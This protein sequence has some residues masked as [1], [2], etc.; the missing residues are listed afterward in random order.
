MNFKKIFSVVIFA[1]IILNLCLSAYLI[2][3][4][5]KIDYLCV[6]GQSCDFVQNSSYA[7][8][9]EIKLIY[10]SV[11]AFLFLLVLF[12]INE[13]WFLL[14]TI[15]GT[16]LAIYFISI[17]LFILKAIC[18]TCFVVDFTMIGIFILS[19]IRYFV[20]KNKKKQIAKKNVKQKKSK[21]K[22]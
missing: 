21:K 1:L 13:K 14:A 15:V 8:L 4:S 22:K 17:Q 12:F 7:S 3:D 2:Y 5:Q 19:I 18:S 6:A 9:F 11:F 20:F 16:I 10:I